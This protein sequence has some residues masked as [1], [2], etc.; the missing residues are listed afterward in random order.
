MLSKKETVCWHCSTVSCVRLAFFQT[1]NDVAVEVIVR[2]WMADIVDRFFLSARSLATR[3]ASMRRRARWSTMRE[4][5]IDSCLA[6]S[7]N[8]VGRSFFHVRKSSEARKA[9]VSRRRLKND[10]L[11]VAILRLRLKAASALRSLWDVLRLS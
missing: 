10:V 5:L 8:F 6:G 7:Q 3:I 2:L 4:R 1:A 11:T 9:E